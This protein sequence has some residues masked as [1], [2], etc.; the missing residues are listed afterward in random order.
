MRAPIAD[1]LEA[2]SPEQRKG[3]LVALDHLTRPLTQGDIVAMLVTRGVRRKEA[4]LIGAAV[5]GL[6]IVALVGGEAPR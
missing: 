2:M 6:H 4:V 5:A 1:V 3:A